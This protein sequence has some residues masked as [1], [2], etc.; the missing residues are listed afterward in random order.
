M[1]VALLV[2][3]GSVMVPE[4]AAGMVVVQGVAAF[5]G[6]DMAVVLRWL[7]P[8]PCQPPRLKSPLLV[9]ATLVV[10]GGG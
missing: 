3:A 2:G 10:V 7:K 8:V 1:G 5:D 9:S 4:V 6:V